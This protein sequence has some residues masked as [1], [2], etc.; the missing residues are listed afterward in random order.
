[1][2]REAWTQDGAVLLRPHPVWQY[3]PLRT[4]GE[5]IPTTRNLSLVRVK[6]NPKPPDFSKQVLWE[7]FLSCTRSFFLRTLVKCVHAQ[8]HACIRR[9]T[10]SVLGSWK[11]GSA[12]SESAACMQTLLLL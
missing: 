1:M 5:I 3:V 6:N 11:R 9:E 12:L 8:A 2:P 10:G 4:W 7:D